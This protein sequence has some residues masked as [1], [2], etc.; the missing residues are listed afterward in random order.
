MHLL[1]LSS[2]SG[3]FLYYVIITV[4]CL[5]VKTANIPVTRR[6]LVYIHV[7]SVFLLLETAEM[8]RSKGYQD[9][10]DSHIRPRSPGPPM[11]P[12]QEIEMASVSVVPDG[13]LTFIFMNTPFR[14]FNCLLKYWFS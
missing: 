8:G 12:P 3:V 13:T 5:N 14:D 11:P 1:Q 9:L 6:S 4:K 10:D 2:V 7:R